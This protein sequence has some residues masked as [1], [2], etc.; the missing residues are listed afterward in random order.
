MAKKKMDFKK[1]AISTLTA[2]GT[3]V[4]AQVVS[5]AVL[6]N[7]PD[8]VDYGMIAAGI[9]LPEVVKGNSMVDSAS[10]ALIAVGGYRMSERLD[11]AGKLGVKPSTAVT[12]ANDF[13]N[14]GSSK[15]WNPAKSTYQGQKVNSSKSDKSNGNVQ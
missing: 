15:G 1:V 5:E 4:I 8:Y 3:G 7:N 10:Q 14:I 13:R 12:G 11:I 9:I 6:P 2:A